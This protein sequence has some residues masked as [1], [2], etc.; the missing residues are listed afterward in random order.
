MT[1]EERAGHMAAVQ[2][3]QA[4]Q[5]AQQNA[6]IVAYFD[7][8]EAK[9]IDALLG[10]DVLDDTKRLRLTVVAQTVRQL[11]QYLNDTRDMGAYAEG[12]LKQLDK[13]DLNGDR[14]AADSSRRG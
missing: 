5:Q 14:T 10:C 1:P 7:G 9:A 12:L 4:A 11:R 8:V 6:A 2:L 13:E 3:S